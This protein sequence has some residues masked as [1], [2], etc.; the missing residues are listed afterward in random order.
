MKHEIRSRCDTVY[1]LAFKFYHTVHHVSVFHSY[2]FVLYTGAYWKEGR[3][4][5]GKEGT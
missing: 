5:G 3:R 4:Q 1:V 2:I